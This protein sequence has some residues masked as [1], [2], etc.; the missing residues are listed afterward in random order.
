M[1]VSEMNQ[2]MNE[3]EF[4]YWNIYYARRRQQQELQEK[5]AMSHGKHH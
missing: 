1:T 4:H 5:L 3:Q 2:K